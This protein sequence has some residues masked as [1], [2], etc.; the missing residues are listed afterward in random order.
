MKKILALSVALIAVV[1]MLGVGTWAYFNDTQTSTGNTFTAGTLDLNLTGGTADPNGIDSVTTTWATP[2]NWKPADT[3]S[4]TLTLHNTGT[5]DMKTVK[6]TVGV[7]DGGGISSGPGGTSSDAEFK[8]E[9]GTYALGAPV[10][11]G[12][13]AVDNISTMIDITT[14]TYD[15]VDLLAQTTPGTFDIATINAMDSNHN[16]ILTMAELKTGTT[17]GYDLIA[18]AGKSSLAHS[19]TAALAM[20]VTFDTLADNVYQGDV[21]TVTFTLTAEQSHTSVA[22]P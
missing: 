4:G 18:A 7:G 11:T 15:G 19:A 17:A 22:Y 1:A 20:T 6:L 10:T 9:G 5:I 8:A 12:W 16:G 3:Q 21:S 13:V 2:S 14:L